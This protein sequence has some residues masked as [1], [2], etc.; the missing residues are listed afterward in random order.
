MICP[1]ANCSG[2]VDW[3]GLFIVTRKGAELG[4]K[5]ELMKRNRGKEVEMRTR[6]EGD[7][8]KNWERV[9]EKDPNPNISLP[10]SPAY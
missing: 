4:D 2:V 8:G 6:S 1:L 3:E 9:T 5:P 10:F 7:R